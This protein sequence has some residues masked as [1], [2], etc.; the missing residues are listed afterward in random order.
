MPD[1]YQLL[2]QNPTLPGMSGGP[3]LN[4]YGELIGIHGRA[5]INNFESNEQ[6]KLVASGTNLAVPIT[7]YQQLFIGERIVAATSIATTADDYLAKANELIGK[8]GKENEVI[9]FA[10]KALNL[11]K[12]KC[13]FLSCLC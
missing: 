1:G 8:K 2:Y 13:I 4:I 5:E 7:Y 10:N 12:R 6:Q 11:G 3:V 9:N